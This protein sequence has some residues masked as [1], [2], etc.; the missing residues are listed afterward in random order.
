M[1]LTIQQKAV[2]LKSVLMVASAALFAIGLVGCDK[3]PSSTNPAPET[4]A[5]APVVKKAPNEMPGSHPIPSQN[6]PKAPS[7]EELEKLNKAEV[8]PAQ[9]E[10]K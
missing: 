9:K 7:I 8:D 6:I 2:I 1:A 4:A 3:K 5:S 10:S